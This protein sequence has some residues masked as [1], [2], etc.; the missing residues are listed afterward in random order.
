MKSKALYRIFRIILG[1]SSVRPKVLIKEINNCFSYRGSW[2]NPNNKNLPS[3]IETIN[4]CVNDHV[5][6]MTAY[7]NDPDTIYDS[8][9]KNLKRKVP[10]ECGQ[11]IL[12]HE[13]NYR[14]IVVDQIL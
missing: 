7:Q 4:V 1:D 3:S 12:Q 5:Y 11:F 14:K 10:F 2:S 8:D 6:F 13:I 9:S